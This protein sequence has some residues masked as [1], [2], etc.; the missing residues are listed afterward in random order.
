[1]W[2][3][4]ARPELYRKAS[5]INYGEALQDH[6]MIIHGMQDDVVLFRDSVI[7]A[8]KLMLLGKN[9]DFVVVPGAAHSWSQKEHYAVFTFKK[10]VEHFDRYLGRGPKSPE[11]SEVPSVRR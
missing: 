6:L 1:M 2:P 10:L 3:P 7:L 4:Q 9:F 5:A 11:A 8:E